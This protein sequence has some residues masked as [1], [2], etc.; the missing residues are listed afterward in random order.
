M[1]LGAD[2]VG[3]RQPPGELLVHVGGPGQ[4]ERVQYIARREHVCV[5]RGLAKLRPHSGHTHIPGYPA[6]ASTS[7]A[8]RAPEASAP[9]TDPVA[10]WSPQTYRPGPIRLPRVSGCG[11]AMAGSA[12]STV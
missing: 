9:W 1:L 10:R 2:P 4:P 8:A 7:R 12:P 3:L 5:W 6:A 11:A